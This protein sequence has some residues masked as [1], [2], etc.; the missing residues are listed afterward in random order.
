MTKNDRIIGYYLVGCGIAILLFHIANLAKEV[1]MG[2]NA[3]NPVF[4]GL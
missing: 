4:G 1:Q 2:L 3:R